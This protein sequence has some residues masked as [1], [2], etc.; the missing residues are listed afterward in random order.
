MNATSRFSNRAILALILILAAAGAARAT[1]PNLMT[2]QGRI[3]ESG[4]PVTGARNV[5]IYL[6]PDPV[7]AIGSCF[8]TGVQSVSVVNGLFR[9]TFTA[10]SGVNWESGQWYLQLQVTGALFTPR[11]LFA[12]APYAV[13][14]SSAATLIPNPGDPGVFIAPNVAIAGDGFS[15]G[16]STFVVTGGNVGVGTA[17]PGSALEVKGA[18]TMSGSSH[19][20]MSGAGGAVPS[21]G[22]NCGGGSI[23]GS[24]TAGR[25]T[26]GAGAAPTLV[27]CTIAFG[28]SWSPNPPVC[29]FTSETGVAVAYAVSAVSAFSVTFKG[30]GSLNNGDVISYICLSY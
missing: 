5:D 1:A 27:D 4:L 14:A 30:P 15:V 6:C 23:V 22:G 18:L 17:T 26:I 3:K 20:R 24:D 10:P 8:D 7:V 25:V 11:E 2:Y 12:S 28:T 21:I 16:A 29:H 9:T 13:Y 19:V